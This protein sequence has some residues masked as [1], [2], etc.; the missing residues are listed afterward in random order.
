MVLLPTTTDYLK[1]FEASQ[2]LNFTDDFKQYIEKDLN[3]LLENASNLKN[4]PRFNALIE[5]NPDIAFAFEAIDLIPQISKIKEPLDYFKIIENSKTL[6]GWAIKPSNEIKYNIANS[7]KLTSL[8]AHSLL[9]IDGN[10]Q[11]LVSLDFM[12]NYGSDDKFYILYLGFLHQQNTKYYNVKFKKKSVSK[13]DLDFGKLMEKFPPNNIKKKK[14]AILFFKEHIISIISNTEKLQEAIASIKRANKDDDKVKITEVH[15]LVKTLIEFSE[16]IATTS[17]DLI[18]KGVTLGLFNATDINTTSIINKTKPYFETAKKVNTIFL[19]LH[20]KNYTNAITSTLEIVSNY[21]N[22]ELSLTKLINIESQLKNAGDITLLKT[23]LGSEKIPKNEEKKKALKD[24]AVLVQQV[25]HRP[26]KNSG[27]AIIKTQFDKVLT[28]LEAD[29]NKDFKTELDKLKEIVKS[30]YEDVLKAYAHIKLTEVF[31]NPINNFIDDK[32]LTNKRKSELKN[33]LTEYIKNVSKAY[34]LE[35][36]E[37]LK[38]SKENL[39]RYLTVY[40]PEMSSGIFKVKDKNVLRIIH[41]ITDIAL[42]DSTEDVESALEAFVLTAGSSSV[43]EKVKS[44]YSINS[45]PGIL[46]GQEFTDND[47]AEHF[48]FTSPIGIYAQLKKGKKTTW[49][50]FFPIIDIAAPVRFRFDD[51]TETETLPDFNFKD[52]LSPGAYI[53]VGVNNSP[54]A[55]NAGIQY[56]SK[57]RNIDN[58]SGILSDIESYRISV[59]IVIDIPLFTLFTS[60]IDD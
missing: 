35:D 15:N 13:V 54:F 28:A 10:K 52:I 49:G 7:I 29:K 17:D 43:K 1:S 12:S 26:P 16:E 22:K 21:T 20:N 14:D 59:G 41:F 40:L 39:L 32:N 4:T 23:F 58:G 42:S 46:F 11:R 33:Y 25:I 50:L 37:G 44:Y 19:D 3:N 60:G 27:L 38:A 2:V 47:T 55:I 51:N 8:L 9:V 18:K 45:Y 57:L 24:L 6:N 53:S 5:R 31:I 56:G 30:K 48:G 34:L 36:D